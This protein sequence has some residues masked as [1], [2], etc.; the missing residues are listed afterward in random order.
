MTATL[1]ATPCADVRD[2]RCSSGMSPARSA[3]RD[4]QRAASVEEY[5]DWQRLRHE[6][7]EP[8]RAAVLRG[9]THSVG[10]PQMAWTTGW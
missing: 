7:L 8:L 6:V 5:F 4:H 2:Q 10:V 9:T 1:S 3:Q